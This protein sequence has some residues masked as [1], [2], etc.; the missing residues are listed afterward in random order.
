MSHRHLLARLVSSAL[1]L[2]AVASNGCAPLTF[3]N[4]A[5]I[6]YARYPSVTVELAGPDG[7]QRQRDYL[8]NE[9]REHSGF[10]R[11]SRAAEPLVGAL[12]AEGAS[13]QLLVE[14]TLDSSYDVDLFDD[15][16]DLD[17]DV[18]YSASVHYR[19]LADG[20]LLDSG[21]ESA[22]D[23][24]TSFDAAEEALDLVVLHYLR[25]YRL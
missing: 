20:T 2:G 10:Q 3:S 19:L 15:D 25:P 17:V 6:D 1:L 18:T 22:E 7:S 24:S 13:A 9:L 11:V 16:D 23:E 8:E 4:E 5:S 12:S 14:L 21:V